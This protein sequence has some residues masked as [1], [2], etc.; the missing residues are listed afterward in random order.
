M[1][2]TV[3]ALN[4]KLSELW[5]MNEASNEYTQLRYV[6]TQNGVFLPYPGVRM[7]FQYDPTTRPW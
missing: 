1:R 2:N 3:S 7:P 6:G 5:K 4:D